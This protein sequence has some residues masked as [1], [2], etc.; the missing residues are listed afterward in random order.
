MRAGTNAKISGRSVLRTMGS[1]GVRL[2]RPSRGTR[3]ECC[4]EAARLGQLRFLNRNRNC[5]IF[6]SLGIAVRLRSRLSSSYGT[7]TS[8]GRRS[9]GKFE[10]Q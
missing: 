7:T 9:K 8:N 2:S 10:L 5:F 3:L 1:L 6:V 4:H